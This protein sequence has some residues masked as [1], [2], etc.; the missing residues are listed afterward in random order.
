MSSED[1]HEAR[2]RSFVA[3]RARV[4]QNAIETTAQN[5]DHLNVTTLE[6]QI[7]RESN[8]FISDVRGRLNEMRNQIKARRPMNENDP[9]YSI[10]MAQYQELVSGA[11]T[12]IQRV[13]KW[14]DTIFEK[15]I[16]LVKKVVEW[17]VDKARTIISVLEMIRDMFKEFTEFFLKN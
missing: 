9:T 2:L 16:G 6:E 13:T 15:I 12:G 17:I 14:I 1:N 5:R 8:R 3:D 4:F 11:S 7:D 10:Q